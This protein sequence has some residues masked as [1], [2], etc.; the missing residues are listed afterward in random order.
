MVQELAPP[1]NDLLNQKSLTQRK[2]TDKTILISTLK[3]T[4]P[5][6]PRKQRGKGIQQFLKQVFI[7]ILCSILISTVEQD[8]IILTH[9]NV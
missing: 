7:E 8:S 5:Y 2:L 4:I 9:H 3:I 1:L 6:N